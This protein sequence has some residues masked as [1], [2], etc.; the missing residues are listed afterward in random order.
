MKKAGF[1]PRTNINNLKKPG[2]SLSGEA[3]G[4]VKKAGFLLRTNINNLKKP[5][6][7]LSGEGTES[8]KKSR[9][10]SPDKYQ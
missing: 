3:T 4:S 10:S 2:F 9:V 6:F 1:L 5:G 7:S 8:V